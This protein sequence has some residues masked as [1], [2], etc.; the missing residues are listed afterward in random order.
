M[1]DPAQAVLQ[2]ARVHGRDGQGPSGASL[3]RLHGVTLLLYPGVVA[4]LGRPADGTA[5]L[6]ELCS[7]RSRPRIGAVLVGGQEPHRNPGRRR[8]IG[9][10]LP[11]PELPETHVDVTGTLRLIGRLRG[12][13]LVA[14]LGALGAGALASRE[15]ASLN[16]AE[17][18][19]VELVIAL[20]TPAPRVVV[21]YEPFAEIGPIDRIAV[22]RRVT[23]L[24]AAGACVVVITAIPGDVEG[25]SDQVHLLARGRLVGTGE[26]VGWPEVTGGQITLWLEGGDGEGARRLATALGERGPSVFG[27]VAWEQLTPEAPALVVA[28]VE[29]VAAGAIVIAET[30]TELG[31]GIA[32]LHS[33]PSSLESI[34]VAAQARAA[35][36]RV[37][38]Q[39]PAGAAP[40]VAGSP[41]SPG[42]VDPGPAP[43]REGD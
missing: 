31:I 24:G 26:P 16:R 33:E 29:D 12:A 19:A 7:G 13:D 18:R 34:T 28:Q 6:A 40:V 30:V 17:A 38:V 25:I 39:A 4:V 23:A 37:G 8:G 21:L 15:L 27:G 3:G 42:R 10:L 32:A 2:L 11:R 9:A 41:T 20:A 22:R 36:L 5:A 1:T 14:E 43:F 35:A